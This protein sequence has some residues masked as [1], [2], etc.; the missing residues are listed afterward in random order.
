MTNSGETDF[1][2]VVVT[3]EFQ[4]HSWNPDNV[5]FSDGSTD[6]VGSFSIETFSAGTTQ[7]LTVSVTVGNG[8]QID[9][10][11]VPMMLNVDDSTGS[12]IGSDDV[13]IVVANWIAYESN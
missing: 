4:H 10:P 7:Q 1:T 3:P 5:S 2:D 9:Y 13:I 8:V 12:R 11:E 6:S